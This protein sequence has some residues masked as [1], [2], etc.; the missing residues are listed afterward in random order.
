L[1]C[2]LRLVLF[3][4]ALH[5]AM[6]CCICTGTLN[7]P[8]YTF[9]CLHTFTIRLFLHQCHVNLL[10]SIE[11]RW[12][13]IDDTTQ[14]I[15]SLFLHQSMIPRR[16]HRHYLIK[17]PRLCPLLHIHHLQCISVFRQPQHLHCQRFI[18]FIRALFSFSRCCGSST[19]KP[20]RWYPIRPLA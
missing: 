5:Y 6:L 12:D 19:A 15:L 20:S 4:Q 18:R 2:C 17:L 7:T 9:V 16:P 8:I 10:C 11:V 1:A 14:Q 13:T 3:S